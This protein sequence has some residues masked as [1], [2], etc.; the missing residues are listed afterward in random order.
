MAEA[1]DK[2]RTAV[3]EAWNFQFQAP[4]AIYLGAKVLNDA[5]KDHRA[6]EFFSFNDPENF[7]Q[8]CGLR[9]YHVANDPHHIKVV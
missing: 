5:Q 1:L 4:T 8:V 9:V 6:P 3:W 7:T 2:I